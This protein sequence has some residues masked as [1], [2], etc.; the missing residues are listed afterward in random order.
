MRPS[1]LIMYDPREEFKKGVNAHIK[2][3]LITDRFICPEHLHST[4]FTSRS[5]K[6]LQRKGFLS[7]GELQY[8]HLLWVIMGG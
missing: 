4:G 1:L 2:L 5:V 7:M 3:L 6:T 8:T